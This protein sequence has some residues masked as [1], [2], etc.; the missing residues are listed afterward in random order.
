M[1]SSPA[2]ELAAF[3]NRRN[4][5]EELAHGTAPD[6]LLVEFAPRVTVVGSALCLADGESGNGAWLA[7]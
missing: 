7:R 4:D 5:G 3:C 2:D 6:G 1:S